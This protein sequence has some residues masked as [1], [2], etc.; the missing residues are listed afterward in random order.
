MKFLKSAIIFGSI[1]FIV[2]SIIYLV[3]AEVFH[4]PYP[5]G[6]LYRMFLYHWEHPY[7]YILVVSI[8]YGILATIWSYYFYGLKTWKRFLSIIGLLVLTIIISSVPC[9][10]L[11]VIHDAQAGY[12]P[13]TSY[14]IKNLLWGAKTGLYVGWLV[15]VLSIPYNLIMLIFGIVITNK[16]S[17]FIFKNKD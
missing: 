17:N 4:H 6:A 13:E 15:V 9:G 10:V 7:Q 3:I 14:F 16:V 11:W 1:F 2:A 8:I 5:L 12:F